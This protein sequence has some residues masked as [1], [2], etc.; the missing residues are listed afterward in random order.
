M[1]DTKIQREKIKRKV[2]AAYTKSPFPVGNSAKDISAQ[3]AWI[4]RKPEDY[5]TIFH[6][7]LFFFVSIF[8][9]LRLR[10]TSPNMEGE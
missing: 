5:R 3:K 10:S 9:V 6:R 1:K 4:K 8:R 7:L 2:A